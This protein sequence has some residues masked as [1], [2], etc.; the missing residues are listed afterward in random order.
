MIQ[1]VDRQLRN[2]LRAELDKTLSIYSSYFLHADTKWTSDY[3]KHFANATI[4]NQPTG[5]KTPIIY[6]YTARRYSIE[7]S[8]LLGT[9]ILGNTR[10]KRSFITFQ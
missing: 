6:P 7:Q 10:D 8:M 3:C 4:E 9:R 1:T 5:Q 2:I